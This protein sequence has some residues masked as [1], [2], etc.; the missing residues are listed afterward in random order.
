MTQ[1]IIETL[2]AIQTK[3]EFYSK[4]TIKSDQLKI[5]VKD[6]GKLSFPITQPQTKKLI[7]KAKPA[8]YGLKEKTFLDSNVRDTW[9]I[10]KSN[11]KIDQKSWNVTFKPLLETIGE[12]LG[13]PHDTRL[14]AHL[15]NM[16][17][18]EKDQF[19]KPHQDSEK[20][21]DMVATLVIIL[22]SKHTGGELIVTH[23][24][25]KKRLKQ[26]TKEKTLTA[27]AF[28]ADCHHEVKPIK[29]G[30]R[31]ALTYN[32]TV[33]Q[34]R[35]TKPAALPTEDQAI[36]ENLKEAL[37]AY[38]T[39]VKNED[40]NLTEQ[41]Q[42]SPTTI[43]N[44][45][46]HE[47]TERGLSW[48]KLKNIDLSRSQF[49]KYAADELD[50]DVFLAQAEIQELWDAYAENDEYEYW[51]HYDEEEEE[52]PSSKNSNEKDY[53]LNDL[54]DSNII[55]SNWI[56]S[57]NKYIEGSEP[58]AFDGELIWTK[59][60]EDFNPFHS[61]YE[62]FMGNWGNT[63]DRW[64][65]RSCIVIT[66]K[67]D[68]VPFL[69]QIAPARTLKELQKTANTA[70]QL[71][72]QQLT[73]LL[74]SWK[75]HFRLDRGQKQN[76][77]TLKLAAGIGSKDLAKQLLEPLNLGTLTYSN[78]KPLVKL[79][80]HYGEKWII[81]VLKAWEKQEKYG[82]EA[83]LSEFPKI[84]HFLHT[85]ESFPNMIIHLL[86][87]HKN[88][89]YGDD[90]KSD[91]FLFDKD[92]ANGVAD[93]EK[94]ISTYFDSIIAAEDQKLFIE[95]LDKLL[96]ESESHPLT[97]QANIIIYLQD[98]IG[99]LENEIF[100]KPAHAYLQKTK[101]NI[102]QTLNH[103]VSL[104]PREEN[105][106]SI[107]QKLSCSCND[108]NTLSQFLTAKEKRETV[109]PL[110]KQRRHHI[111]RI[112][113]QHDLPINHVTR[114]SGSP[115]KLVLTKTNLLFEREVSYTKA[116]KLSLKKLQK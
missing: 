43:A 101:T 98:K 38:F 50:L 41:N 22:P 29:T 97:S 61:E 36:V 11:I 54:I 65:K 62:G 71:A 52:T 15:H 23:H 89:I 116:L 87:F 58:T 63:L 48:Q 73:S 9:E 67:A 60:V 6:V 45:L 115:Q 44:L 59:A 55:M 84:I 90:N 64:Y 85:Q 95:T 46:D 35:N 5:E 105:D 77:S 19:F 83:K 99:A 24:D 108:C 27:I 92:V 86:Q 110:N 69:F 102:I 56:D 100:S 74:P 51:D 37:S 82:T 25:S 26:T 7:K 42:S 1:A 17:I 106:W 107:S 20:L 8:K 88:H 70:P 57:D 66:K 39:P 76:K 103:T 31:V 28:Y 21:D 81:S 33:D 78:I 113:E 10:A 18:Y 4:K 109:W 40:K 114:R 49:I 16:L 112:I 53:V 79:I 96:N 34:D 94:Q 93:N 47:Y 91:D 13:L 72:Q 111:H 3:G 2:N 14:R 68:R 32:L 75:K 12:E 30:Y 104:P 80:E